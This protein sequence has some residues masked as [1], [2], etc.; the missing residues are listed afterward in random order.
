M[1]KL[2]GKQIVANNVWK[3]WEI[4]DNGRNLKTKIEQDGNIL[5]ESIVQALGG[6]TFDPTNVKHF[7]PYKLDDNGNYD[8]MG[9]NTD[10]TLGLLLVDADPDNDYGVIYVDITVR[11]S[12]RE[13][14]DI[15]MF[16]G[17]D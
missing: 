14:V 15:E 3:F 1:S 13:I 11:L 7:E 10:P 17:N 9:N 6:E 8:E 16:G 4:T 2:N 12:D 5:E